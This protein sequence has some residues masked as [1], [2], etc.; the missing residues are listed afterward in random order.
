MITRGTPSHSELGEDIS[1]HH[2]PDGPAFDIVLIVH[3][4]CVVVSLVTLVAGVTTAS[5]LRTVLR[6]TTALPDAV[7]RYFRPGVNWA[8][9]SVYGIPVFG[10]LLLALSHGAY[11]LHDGWVVAGLI[12]LVG[13]V[14][15]AEGRLWPAERRLQ[16]GVVPL[17]QGGVPAGE[18][19]LRD[20]R[21]MV[22][23]GSLALVLVVLGSA[24]MVAQ[25]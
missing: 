11:S 19:V 7:A 14:V 21:A 17:L 25:P 5:R 6:G 10:F 4:G 23:S 24:L 22:M 8:G 3:V 18:E 9:R 12:I 16:V 20:T 2:Q 13:V 1:V 15:V